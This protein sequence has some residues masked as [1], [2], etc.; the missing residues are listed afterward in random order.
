MYGVKSPSLPPAQPK[1]KNHDDGLRTIQ[2]DREAFVVSLVALSLL[3]SFLVFL[4]GNPEQQ[5]VVI[6]VQAGIC[7]VLLGDALLRLIR[8]RGKRRFLVNEHGWLYIVGS[9]PIPFIC[10]LRLVPLWAMVRRLRRT[11]YEVLGRVVVRRRAQST[12]LSVILV[13]I[14]V[15]EIGSIAILGAESGAVTGNIKTAGD[16]LWW[17]VVTIATVGYG[18]L[19][20]TTGEG[21]IV[22]VFMM[23]VGVG[24]FAA[25]SSFL[26]QWF[27]RQRATR[28]GDTR[29]APESTP[30]EAAGGGP[31][32]TWEHLRTLLDE[33][34]EA[35]RREVEELQA[36]LAALEAPRKSG[37]EEAAGSQADSANVGK[38]Q[39]PL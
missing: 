35:H 26:A 34:E 13:A 24:V 3:N 39:P 37:R 1:P 8:A 15:L 27:L 36:R 12:L 4:L 30:P 7:V 19:Y 25:L 33:R 2:P 31:P 5:R 18:D 38:S 20:P 23:V 16:A 28:H 22:G 10:L 29:T 9:L 17:A 32:L 21:R 6:I 14:L 11:D